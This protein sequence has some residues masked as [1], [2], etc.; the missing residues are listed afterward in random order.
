V[1]PGE[2][3]THKCIR[4]NYEKLSPDCKQAEFEHLKES[5]RLLCIPSTRYLDTLVYTHAH[6]H[7]HTHTHTHTH[8]RAHTR[9]HTSAG[10]VRH[11][12]WGFLVLFIVCVH[13]TPFC[14]PPCAPRLL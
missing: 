5:V 2:G 9:A 13:R 1:K 14:R 4:D 8:L 3:R 12:L 7:G 10:V 11:V 6:G